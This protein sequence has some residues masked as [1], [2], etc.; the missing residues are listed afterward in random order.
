MKNLNKREVVIATGYVL[1]VTGFLWILKFS[2]IDA[3]LWREVIR[4]PICVYYSPTPPTISRQYYEDA[5]RDSEN[6]TREIVGRLLDERHRVLWASFLM[7]SG[8]L[9]IHLGSRS[10]F[11]GKANPGTGGLG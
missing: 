1:L 8:G 6:A 2:T 5:R 3:Q 10:S 9:L 11:T 4:P 7:L